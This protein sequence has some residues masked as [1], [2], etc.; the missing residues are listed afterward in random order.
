MCVCL[1]A[2]FSANWNPIGIPFGTKLLFSP[3]KVLTQNIFYRRAIPVEAIHEMEI[4]PGRS[5][6]PLLTAIGTGSP[7]YPGSQVDENDRH[8]WDVELPRR[9]H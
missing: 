6:D 1:F 8:G 4:V 7:R 3:E 9:L 2:F 5:L